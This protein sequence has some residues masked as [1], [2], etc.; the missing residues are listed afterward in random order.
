MRAAKTSQKRLS[1]ENLNFNKQ[2][3]LVYAE[4]LKIEDSKFICSHF[5]KIVPNEDTFDIHKDEGM[6]MCQFCTIVTQNG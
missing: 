5:K 3:T 6:K 2:F 1:S 4:E